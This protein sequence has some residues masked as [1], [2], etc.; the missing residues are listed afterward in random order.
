MLKLLIGPS[1]KIKIALRTARIV[2]LYKYDIPSQDKTGIALT[3]C[4][5]IVNTAHVAK[6][7]PLL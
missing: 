3:H 7:R 6:S 1:K 5:Q 4:R 2:A